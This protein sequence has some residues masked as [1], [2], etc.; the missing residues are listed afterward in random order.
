MSRAGK[1]TRT[2]GLSGAV[3]LGLGSILGTGAFVSLGLAVGVAGALSIWALLIATILAGCN[4][5]SSAQLAANHPVSG[6]TYAYGYRYLSPNFGF[7]A[8]ICFLLA[9]SASAAAASIGLMGYITQSMGWTDAPLNVLAALS[10]LLMTALVTLGIRRA[11]AANTLLVS[12]TLLSL[13]VLIS[14]SAVSN[15]HKAPFE[16]DTFAPQNLFEASALLFVAFTGYG[17]IAT[18]GEEVKSPRKNIPLAIVVTLIISSLLYAGI[19]LA[20]LKILGVAEFAQVTSRSSAPLQAIA[21]KLNYRLLAEIV[22]I[23]AATAMAG[24]LLNLI[25]GLS[26]VAFSMGREGDLPKPLGRLS[27]KRQEPNISTWFMGIA[28]ALIALCGGLAN[29]W[30]FS[31]FTVLLYYAIT[32]LASL[33]LKRPE[34]LYPRLVSIL[35]LMG[36]LGLAV[37]VDPKVIGIGVFV[38]ALAMATRWFLKVNERD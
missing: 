36:C 19:L 27:G 29:V 5:L 25:L 33:Q 37:F 34:R 26:R 28:I 1:L 16:W 30:S 13:I 12:M 10:V 35:G 8:G 11:G 7:A 15:G 3:F 22:T 24:V 20:G 21:Q 2:V 32:N 4:A 6:G 14:A 9:K 31:A 38:M 23:G 18:L 17:R